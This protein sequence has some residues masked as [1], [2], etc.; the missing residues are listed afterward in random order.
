MNVVIKKIQDNIARVII[1]KTKSIELLLTALAAGGHCL[2]DDV[3]GTGKTKLANALS[4]SIDA[5][6][7]RIQF[8]P[9][10]QPGDISGIYFY[11]RKSEDFIFR[12]GPLFANI[13]LADEINR[14]VPRTQSILLEAMEE[15]QV[16]IEGN[17]K[18]LDA[19]FM[20]IATQNPL[21][22]QGTFPLPEAQLDRFLLKISMD[23]P[24]INEE[25]LIIRRYQSNDP[26]PDLQKV[27]SAEDIITL[28]KQASSIYVA[29]DIITYIAQLSNASRRNENIQTGL[30]PR[31]SLALLKASMAYA[32]IK[33]RDYVIPDDVKNLFLPVA[34][35]RIVPGMK[36]ELENLSCQNLLKTVLESVEAPV[37]S[38]I[39]A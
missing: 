8:T 2:I 37:E 34:S 13:I 29:D 20:V 14:A 4:K 28:Q 9:D 24:D 22:F 19:P 25:E 26:L 38:G 23:Y 21:E 35:H 31:A 12:A 7:R 18:K 1:G 27:C 5:N 16:T 3:P 32:L 10:L 36:A 17:T 11:S 33:G 15:R 30:S 6:F 39:H